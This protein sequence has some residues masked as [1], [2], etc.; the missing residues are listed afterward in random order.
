MKI[1]P[2]KSTPLIAALMLSGLL[3][4]SFA[5]ESAEEKDAATRNDI[6]RD[7]QKSLNRLEETACM[8][9]DIQCEA[10]KLKNRA[11]EGKDTIKDKANE[12]NNKSDQDAV[13]N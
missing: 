5:Y 9:D 3:P 10:T 13:V 1:K 12:L 6:K 11:I 4:A 8:K 7:V 2:M